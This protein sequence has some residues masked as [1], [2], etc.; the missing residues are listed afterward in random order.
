MGLS[1]SLY[2]MGGSVKTSEWVSLFR[3]SGA[4]GPLWLISYGLQWQEAASLR[5]G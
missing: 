3:P 2:E 4:A 1:F 5:A